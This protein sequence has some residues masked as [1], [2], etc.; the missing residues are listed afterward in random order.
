MAAVMLSNTLL[1]GGYQLNRVVSESVFLDFFDVS[2]LAYALAGVPVCI[3]AL[4]YLYGI[5]LSK[6]G[7]MRS[8]VISSLCA[9][10]VFTACYFLVLAG[11]KAAAMALFLFSASYIVI[12]YEQYWSFIN[13]VLTAASAKIYNGPITGFGSLGTI[14]GSYFISSSV[15]TVGTEQLLL[16]SAF[17]FL[18][19]AALAFA[20]YKLAGEPQPAPEEKG[21]HQGTLHLSLLV[22]NRPL[23]LITVII[24]LTQSLSAIADIQFLNLLQESQLAK[25]ARTAYLGNFWTYTGACSALFQFLVVPLLLSRLPLRAFHL[26]IPCANF[27][28]FL[29]VFI[30]PSLGLAALS[31]GGFKV[32]D[33]S[34]FKSAKELVYISLS[35]DARYRVKQVIDSFIYRFSKGAGAFAIGVARPAFSAFPQLYALSAMGVAAAWAFTTL[36]LTA[37]GKNNHER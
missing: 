8:L 16:V 7:G 12:L 25:D 30:H 18:P 3:A 23:L 6:T 2:M 11:S 22:K 26:L 20:A 9:S 10:A 24:M 31:K 19:G 21:G 27:A 33:Y 34:F 29:A 15:K 17:L 37:A 4:V 14:A 35:F 28:L 5:L 32:L 1:I 36:P 13:S